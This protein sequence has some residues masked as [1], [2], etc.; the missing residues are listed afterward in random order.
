MKA[1]AEITIRSE[2]LSMVQPPDKK[3]ARA[4]VRSR[5]LGSTSVAELERRQPAEN[6]GWR[7]E[8]EGCGVPGLADTG[9][10]R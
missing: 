7:R 3:L 6:K 10:L 4:D 8:R 5:S 2:G 9:A 1:K